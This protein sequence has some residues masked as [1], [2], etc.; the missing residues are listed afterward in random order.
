MIPRYPLSLYRNDQYIE[1]TNFAKIFFKETLGIYLERSIPP[2]IVYPNPFIAV[3]EDTRPE[4]TKHFFEE[5][6]KDRVSSIFNRIELRGSK[7]EDYNNI[8]LYKIFIDWIW[9]YTIFFF[10]YVFKTYYGIS[11]F[12]L[13]QR[14]VVDVNQIRF[15]SLF[16]EKVY[17]WKLQK[18]L[19][20]DREPYWPSEKM[21]LY[22]FEI[23]RRY[24]YE[25]PVG[26]IDYFLYTISF[27]GN[28]LRE[29]NL[30]F[31]VCL[32]PFTYSIL[33][34]FYRM[35]PP[36]FNGLFI[37]FL[38]CSVLYNFS[39][40]RRIYMK[41]QNWGVYV[42]SHSKHSVAVIHDAIWLFVILIRYGFLHFV[43]EMGLQVEQ[44]NDEL[45]YTLLDSTSM[46]NWM[47]FGYYMVWYFFSRSMAFVP[48]PTLNELFLDEIY[49]YRWYKLK[50]FDYTIKGKIYE[51]Y[52][53]FEGDMDRDMFQPWSKGLNPYLYT[54]VEK[55]V[56]LYFFVYAMFLAFSIL[57]EY[58]CV[59]CFYNFIRNF[60][61]V[62]FFSK[63]R[64]YYCSEI[65]RQN[66]KDRL[67][68]MFTPNRLKGDMPKP[69]FL[70]FYLNLD[71]ADDIDRDER[72]GYRYVYADTDDVD[73]DRV[74]D[75]R[76]HECH[77]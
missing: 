44:P 27:L 54:G 61:R 71:F 63:N 75:S 2:C 24:S 73:D 31:A 9:Y 48:T 15:L 74:K 66:E 70:P 19:L 10:F 53:K 37:F 13:F 38:F 41:I 49:L 4:L 40:Y 20:Q 58:V 57:I 35:N 22:W 68:Y 16:K 33:L 72:Y 8:S 28:V 17:T 1:T 36:F 45:E 30:V 55:I 77:E 50:R 51:N 67:N 29:M 69:C 23:S 25:R 59:D 64:V 7:Y 11:F 12:T 65:H 42:M 60:F 56:R 62:K 34:V 43:F 32:I 26:L 14:Y 46:M 52:E 47:L 39:C 76:G 3:E 18:C 5:Y 6:S 21:A